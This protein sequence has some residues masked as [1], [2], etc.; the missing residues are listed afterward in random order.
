MPHFYAGSALGFKAG[1]TY[2][3]DGEDGSIPCGDASFE[4]KSTDLGLIV[5]AGVEFGRT[6]VSLRLDQGLSTQVDGFSV[7]NRAIL[8]VV[9]RAFGGR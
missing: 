5:G 4:A 3:E 6:A 1:C 2:A 9:T 8:L 7:K